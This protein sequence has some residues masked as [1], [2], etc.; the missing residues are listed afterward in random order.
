MT[1]GDGGSHVAESFLCTREDAI[2]QVLQAACMNLNII[3]RP[4]HSIVVVEEDDADKENPVTRRDDG[5]GIE[6]VSHPDDTEE[7]SKSIGGDTVYEVPRETRRLPG[8][9]VSRALSGA[10]YWDS[11]EMIIVTLSLSP[12]LIRDY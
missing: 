7:V 11:G 9:T 10:S 1:V 6:V 12:L 2:R 3:P 4:E 8:T 5:D